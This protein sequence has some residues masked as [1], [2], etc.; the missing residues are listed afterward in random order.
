MGGFDKGLIMDDLIKV[1]KRHVKKL[2]LIPGTGT[3]KLTYNPQP[4]TNN[5]QLMGYKYSTTESLKDAVVKAMKSAKKG[6]V[7]LFSPAFASFGMFKNEY[8]RGDQFNKIIKKL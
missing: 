5:K 6:D 2:I 4:T 3:S 1:I 7:V 8:D